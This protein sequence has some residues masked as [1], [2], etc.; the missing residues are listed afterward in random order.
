MWDGKVQYMVYPDGTPKGMKAVLE[1]RGVNTKGMKA[2]DLKSAL[3]THPDFQE[4]KPLLEEFVGGRGHICVY[5]P[6]FHCELSPIERVWCHSKKHTCAYANGSIVRL[7]KIVPEGL[8]SVSTEMI[9]NSLEHVGTT[10]R[11]T[12][13]EGLT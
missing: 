11:R 5:Y 8:D 7:H 13:R 1:E 3:K 6:K 12:Y 10:K 9:K 4:Q 2:N